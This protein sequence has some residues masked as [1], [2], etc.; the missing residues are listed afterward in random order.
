MCWSSV[1]VTFCSTISNTDVRLVQDS[2][3]LKGC[4]LAAK[5]VYESGDD[6]EEALFIVSNGAGIIDKATRD[7]Q[8]GRSVTGKQGGVSAVGNDGDSAVENTRRVSSLS[9]GRRGLVVDCSTR[10]QKEL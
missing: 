5:A 7:L 6:H 2:T 3:H 4:Y 8:K 1:M 9:F 10:E